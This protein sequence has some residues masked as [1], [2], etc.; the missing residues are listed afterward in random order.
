MVFLTRILNIRARGPDPFWKRQFAKRLTWN[1]Y[2]RRRNCHKLSLNYLR[3]A[4]RYSTEY[5]SKL[6]TI[7]MDNLF[8]TRIA[9]GCAEHGVEYSPFIDTLRENNIVLDRKVLA[10]LAIYEPRTFQSLCEVVK[11]SHAEIFNNNLNPSRRIFTKGM[12]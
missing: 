12:L 5:R 10:D 6:K 2:G 9:A 11:R 1:F 3:R 8:E 4:L 7:N